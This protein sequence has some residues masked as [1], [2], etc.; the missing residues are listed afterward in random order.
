MEKSCQYPYTVYRSSRQ[1]RIGPW[2]H[3]VGISHVMRTLRCLVKAHQECGAP[4]IRPAWHA[5][6]THRQPSSGYWNWTGNGFALAW[7]R[8]FHQR[9]KTNREDLGSLSSNVKLKQPGKNATSDSHPMQ[10]AWAISNAL[11]HC[12]GEPEWL[13]AVICVNFFNLITFMTCSWD[14][15]GMVIFNNNL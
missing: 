6:K 1:S 9:C 11:F 5:G 3:R 7:T 12:E 8:D 2:G 4:T 13:T 14:N 15:S 10:T